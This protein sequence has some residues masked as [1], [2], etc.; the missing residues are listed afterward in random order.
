MNNKKNI[1]MI[2][3]QNQKTK[4]YKINGLKIMKIID[5][6]RLSS[7]IFIKKKKF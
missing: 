1:I 4:L 3:L 6:K 7:R 5:L 2:M